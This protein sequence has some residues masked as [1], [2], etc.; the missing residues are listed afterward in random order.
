MPAMKDAQ[1]FARRSVLGIEPYPTG[2]PPEEL[3][4][5]LGLPELALLAN[6]ECP[7]GPSPLA[8]EAARRELERM[9]LYPDGGCAA[10]SR[11][12]AGRLGVDP[13]MLLFG[14][15]GDNC[16]SLVAASFLDA[17]DEVIVGDPSFPVYAIA[18]GAAGARVE[19]VP[20]AGFTHDL[21][22]MRRRIG[23][24]TRL[25]IVCNPN[26][27]TGGLAD[28][29][30]LERFVRALPDHVLLLLDEA[31]R[32]FN[33][34][35]AYPDGLRFIREGRPVL[36]LRTFS[37]VY[38]LAGLRV[39]YLLGD[40]DLLGLARRAREA[41]PVSRPA[42]AAA[43]AALDDEA[44]VRRVLAHNAACRAY[45]YRELKRLGLP[46]APTAANFI[47]VDLGRDAREVQQALLRR[48]ILIRPGHL[49]NLPTWARIT[50]GT[51]EQNRRLV[52]ALAALLG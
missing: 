12:L 39:G 43:L 33:P 15:G 7:L 13:S 28:G 11:K 17:G 34:D 36:S 29:A 18:A 16:I 42:Q 24:R 9:H 52:E 3:Q 41:F 30:E 47:F 31:Y 48:G 19:R 8:V 5:A 22:G 2:K 35:P 50:F 14:N 51:A 44:F 27:P 32:E 49:W 6:N 25:L 38:G 45:F 1:R 21:E 20:L 10:L 26:N 40:A 46:H 23:A 37:K 4:A